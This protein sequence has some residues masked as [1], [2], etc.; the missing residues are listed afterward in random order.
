[1][2]TGAILAV[3]CGLLTAACT[4]DPN[5]YPVESVGNA[6]PTTRGV[7]LSSRRVTL[8]DDQA[9]AA[10]LGGAAGGAIIGASLSRSGAPVGAL[11]GALVGVAVDLNRPKLM[12]TE[13]VIR[14]ET[15]AT[16]TVLQIESEAMPVQQHVMVVY[17]SPVRVLA[18]TTDAPK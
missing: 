18:D 11:A 17:G 9:G 12:G 8:T 13:Y 3:A 5:A 7:V 2:R 4:L 14:T 6:S 15:G 16:M 1:M 10:T